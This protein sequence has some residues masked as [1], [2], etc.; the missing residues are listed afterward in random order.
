MRRGVTSIALTST[1]FAEHVPPGAPARQPSGTSL[2]EIAD[3]CI[4]VHLPL[5]DAV[6]AVEGIPQKMRHTSTYAN[7]F[8]INLLM[9]TTAEKLQERGERPPVWTS[10]NLPVVVRWIKELEENYAYR[11]RHLL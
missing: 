4:D 11:C 6:E 9:M 3:M 5:G 10:A 1:S 2:H 7:A 8:A